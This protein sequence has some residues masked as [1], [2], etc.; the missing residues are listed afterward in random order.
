MGICIALAGNPNCGK[1]TMFNDLTGANQYVGNWPGVTVEKKEGKYTRDKDVTITDLPG[2]YSLSPYSP[3]EIVAR[4]YL[5][6]G[7][8][9]AVINLVDATNLERNLYLTSQILNLGVPVVIALNMMDLV[10]KNGDK[11]DVDG[12]SRELG[13]PIVPTSAL[14]GRGMEDVVK[15]AIDAA[16]SKKVPASQMKFDA[17]VE[18]ALVKIEGVLGD[19]VASNAARWYAIKLFEAE[20]KTIADLKLSQAD[21]DAISA[22]RTSIED[23][24]DDDAESIITAER[25]DAIS[26]VVD[27]TVKRTRTG[28]T[29][30]QKIDRVVTNRWLGLPIFIVIMFFVYWLAVSVGGGVVTDWAN[31]GISGDGWLYTGNAAFDEATEEYEDAHSQVV[32]YVEN[33]LGEDEESELPSDAS[34][35]VLD[36][37]AAEEPE[38]PEDGAD[39]DAVADYE[40]AMAE[41]EEA[42]AIV[43]DFDEQAQASHAVATM[44][45]EDED[46]N[47]EEQSITFADYQ[48]ALEVEEPDP[49]DGTWGLWIPGLGA[50]IA[51][52]MEAADVAPWLQSLVNDGIVSGVGAVIGFIPQM[53][54]LFLL[55]GLLELCGYMSRVAFIMDRIFR[56][57]G[58]SGKS[59]IPMLIASG[60]GVPAV[61]STKTIENEMDRRMTIMTTTMIPCGAKMPIIALVFGALASGDSSATWYVAP[62]FYFLG[63]IAIILSG[64]MLKKTKLFAGDATPFVMELPEYHMPTVKSILLSMW[65]RVKGYIIKAGTIIF[66]ST[67]VIWFLMNFGDAGEGFGLLDPDAP[68]YMEHSLMAGLGNLLAW[69]FAPLGFDNWQAAATAVTGLVAKE[70]VVATVGI[71]TQLAD[72]GEADPQL[73]FGFLQMLGGSTAAVVAF[74][75]FNLLC[76]PCFAAMGTIRQQQNSPKWFWIT[77]GYL[78]GFAWCVG[79][80]LYQFV[81]LATGEVEFNVFTV[82]AIVIAAAMLFQIF[83]PM[84][85]REEKQDK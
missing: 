64:I 60:C 37:L 45:V 5:L 14:K 71:I 63:V 78:C 21:L 29:T 28:L 46:G 25:Y 62:M 27:K 32:A 66:L 43:A 8:P 24:L 85:K 26:H 80:M 82:V 73:W 33:I 30:S 59:F 55:L 11:I 70:N 76:A 47:V 20:D 53:V 36:A 4:D 34:Q 15:A 75:A 3:E 12:L 48:K 67:I 13:C 81:G 56:K 44:E 68:D 22:I 17:A 39:E 51:D 19:K 79:T 23:K 52:A 31:D 61:M 65:E 58:L 2:I 49:S 41:Y 54:I 38:A 16:R 9:D 10:E 74:C 1:T 42:Q 6:E 18:E 84:P 35:E 7:G 50:I 57:F 40:D 69:I 83:R 72:Y 77:I